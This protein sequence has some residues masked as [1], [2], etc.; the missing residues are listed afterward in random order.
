MAPVATVFEQ[1]HKSAPVERWAQYD[2]HKLFVVSPSGSQGD[3]ASTVQA[4]VGF[5][6]KTRTTVYEALPAR[7]IESLKAPRLLYGADGG[8]VPE[9]LSTEATYLMAWC[10]LIMFLLAIGGS[11]YRAWTR[12]PAK[13]LLPV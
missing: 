3:H 1:I 5:L 13:S 9:L 4:L 7:P 11:F 12:A 2:M 8:S 10:V 6:E